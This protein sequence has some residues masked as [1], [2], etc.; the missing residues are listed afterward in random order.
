MP[1]RRNNIGSLGLEVKDS[2]SDLHQSRVHLILK[3][4]KLEGGGDVGDA[5]ASKLGVCP[6]SDKSLLP[7]ICGKLIFH[8]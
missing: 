7:I 2:L 8:A 1:G 5:V 3:V 4:E 6:V